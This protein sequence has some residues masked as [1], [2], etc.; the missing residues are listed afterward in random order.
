[1]PPVYTPFAMQLETLRAYLDTLGENIVDLRPM[2]D[3]GLAHDHV[4]IRR[5]N[6]ADWVARL[7]KQSQM[8]LEP[9]A[10]LVFQA[11]CYQRASASGHTPELQAQL[12]IDATLPRGGLLVTAIHGRSSRLPEDLP[13]IAK[14]LAA[15]HRLPLPVPAERPPLSSA[16]S[17]WQAMRDEIFSQARYFD[18]LSPDLLDATA[19]RQIDTELAILDEDAVAVASIDAHRCLISFDA[20]PGNFLI[21]PE[22]EAV[23]VDLEKCR[24]SHPGFDLAHASLYTSTTWDPASHA[25]LDIDSVLDFYRQ[26]QS[27]LAADNPLVDA[28]ALVATRRAM[29]L[30]SI[31]W[32]AK[33]WNLHR[34]ER[35]ALVCGEDWSTSLSD[36]TLIAHVVGRVTHFLSTPIVARVVDETHQ[37]QRHLTLNNFLCAG[38]HAR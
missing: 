29:W 14:A 7:P 2:P 36:P 37:L 26:W 30:W 25:V 19:R 28:E 35:D 8:Q 16:V 20:H 10:N 23:L 3:T 34:R 15:I 9:E 31:T 17:P 33:W 4:W 11:N 27:W 21:T 13:G 38:D 1:M 22:G 6:G 5:R 18:T 32:C 24:Y 12:P